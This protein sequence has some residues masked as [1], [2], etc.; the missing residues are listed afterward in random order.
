MSEQ[1]RAPVTVVAF[2]KQPTLRFT[3]G[4][5]TSFSGSPRT[6]LPSNGTSLARLAF[7]LYHIP[8]EGKEWFENQQAVAASFATNPC[9]FRHFLDL[10][11]DICHYGE[12]SSGSWDL[13]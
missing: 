7:P 1:Q 10:C 9:A 8:L 12:A 2:V 6:L 4:W 5:P 11:V 13:A 3:R